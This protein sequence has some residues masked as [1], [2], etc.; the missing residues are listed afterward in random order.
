MNIKIIALAVI[1]FLI[2]SLSS[3]FADNI[4]YIAMER[5]LMNYEEAKTIQQELQEKRDAYQQEV[6][7]KR[8]EIE[9]ARKAKKSEEDIQRLVTETEANL[10]LK[11][12][13]IFRNEVE[14]QEKLLAKII[15][16]GNLVAK[17]YG[18]DVVLDKRVVYSG[19]FDLTDFILDKLNQ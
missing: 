3:L 2:S 7:E 16:L 9:D 14:K 6:V 15:N 12:E 1:T 11:Q 19:G 5:I 4:G 18:I 10:K 17:E 8:K 13:G